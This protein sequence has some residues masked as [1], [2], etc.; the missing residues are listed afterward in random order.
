[1]KKI[2]YK[3]QIKNQALSDFGDDVCLLEEGKDD[4]VKDASA[5]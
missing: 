3:E 4:R 2:S 5:G 1:M